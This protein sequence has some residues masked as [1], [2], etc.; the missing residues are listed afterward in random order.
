MIW[1]LDYLN[2]KSLVSCT[3]ESNILH[4]CLITPYFHVFLETLG[5]SG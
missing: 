2:Q 1:C 4:V 5:F 3:K